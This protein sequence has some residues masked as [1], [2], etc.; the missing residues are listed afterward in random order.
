MKIV[1]AEPIGITA[2]E[3]QSFADEMAAQGHTTIYFD[4]PVNSQSEMK[5]RIEEADIV[6]VANHPISEETL[7]SCRTIRLIA[8]A[9]TGTDHIPQAICKEQQIEIR[10]A[11]GYSTHS[12]AELTISLAISLLRRIPQMDSQ[13]RRLKTREGFLGGELYG[14]TFGI[15]GYGAIGQRVAHIAH[16]M[17]CNI[18]VY[19]RS[20]KTDKHIRQVAINELFSQSDIISV[21]L[22]ATPDTERL[23]NHNLISLMKPNAVV[24]NTARG[25]LIDYSSLS[26][27]LITGKI[28]GAAI[29]VYETEPPIADNH[30]LLAAPNTILLPHIGYAT[31]EAIKRRTA[32]TLNNIREW[33]LKTQTGSN[34]RQ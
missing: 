30:P 21:H 14:K 32:I 12:V 11:A 3:K 13:T 23:I 26:T 2:P 33:L 34:I 20:R 18:L 15:L 31:T 10:N 28:A 19:N 24:V 7:K 8:V 6:V 16:A 9:F 27:A 1:F 17:G 5:E 22:P 25:Q 29:D 4:K